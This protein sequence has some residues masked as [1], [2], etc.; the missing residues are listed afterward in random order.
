M[1]ML[2]KT[3]KFMMYSGYLYIGIL[4]FMWLLVMIKEIKIS[5]GQPLKSYLR[6]YTPVHFTMAVDWMHNLICALPKRW[7]CTGAQA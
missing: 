3:N 4:Q 1:R 7:C 6:L 5:P 2:E